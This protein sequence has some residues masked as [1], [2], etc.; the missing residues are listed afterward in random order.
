MPLIPALQ[1]RRQTD[2]YDF[3][4][5]LVYKARSGLAR[6]T[7]RNPENINWGKD[8][9]FKKKLDPSLTPYTTVTSN[10]STDQRPETLK[11]P[12]K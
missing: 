1:R 6:A 10:G 11:L 12:G 8:G 7:Q 5:S 2:L 4:A 3:E 9:I